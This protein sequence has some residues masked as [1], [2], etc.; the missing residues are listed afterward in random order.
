MEEKVFLME[1]ENDGNDSYS[2]ILPS[3]FN[4]SI[5]PF[6]DES[7]L[8]DDVISSVKDE[9]LL[10]PFGDGNIKFWLSF[11]KYKFMKYSAS[12]SCSETS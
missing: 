12:L 4:N 5:L 9:F 1:F 3:F 7:R 11:S 2:V 10:M 8:S 6:S